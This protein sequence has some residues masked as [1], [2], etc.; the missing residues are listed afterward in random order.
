MNATPLQD[1]VFAVVTRIPKGKVLTY[2]YV[3]MHAGV[4][5]P[6]TVGQ[7]LHRNKHP[8]IIPCHRVVKSD[9]SMATGYAFGGKEQQ[10]RLLI[11][12]GI[13]FKGKLIDLSKSL[14]RPG[15]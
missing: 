14:F 8:K 7:I 2:K 4:K 15:L 1:K 5:N 3:A 12:E 11:E 10:R 6:R 9:G 13:Q